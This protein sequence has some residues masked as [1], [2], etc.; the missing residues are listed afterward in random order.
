MSFTGLSIRYALK[1]I[2][3]SLLIFS[4]SATFFLSNLIIISYPE[5][6]INAIDSNIGSLISFNPRFFPRF[7]AP[8][9]S[10]LSTHF[11]FDILDKF[12]LL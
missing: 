8:E 11:D 4:L 5:S 9:I 3:S 12:S 7:Q 6:L 2:L 10:Y 1:R